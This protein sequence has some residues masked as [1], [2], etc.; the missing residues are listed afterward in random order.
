MNSLL[1]KYILKYQ[2][3]WNKIFACT[4]GHTMFIHKFQKE[5]IFFVSYIKKRQNFVFLP[6]SHKMFLFVKNLCGDIECPDLY[7]QFIFD[8]LTF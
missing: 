3:I 5:R 1:E 7:D 4:S 2:K 8:F 6:M